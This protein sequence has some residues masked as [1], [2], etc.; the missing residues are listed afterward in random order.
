MKDEKT[1]VTSSQ[2]GKSFRLSPTFWPLKKL[3]V[4]VSNPIPVP[5]F[6][7]HTSHFIL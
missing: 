7:L 6:I 2:V 4:G 5:Y 1:L 3:L